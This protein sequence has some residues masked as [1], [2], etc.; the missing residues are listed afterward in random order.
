MAYNL[1]FVRKDSL[2]DVN[3][4]TSWTPKIY[5]AEDDTEKEE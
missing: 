2:D 1:S 5:I 3:N 4:T